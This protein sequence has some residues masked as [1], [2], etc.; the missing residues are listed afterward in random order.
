MASL[1][2]QTKPN[3]LT[4]QLV[5]HD[6]AVKLSEEPLDDGYRFWA[7][8]APKGSGK[9][10]VLYN[11]LENKASPWYKLFDRIYMFSPTAENT[12]Y[13]KPLLKELKDSGQFYHELNEKNL[14]ECLEHLEAFNHSFMNK[15]HPQTRDQKAQELVLLRH[16][17]KREDMPDS[18]LGEKVNKRKPHNLIIFDDCL[19]ELAKSTAKSIQSRLW[20]RNRHYFTNIALTSQRYLKLNPT[21]RNNLDSISFWKTANQKEYDTLE[22]DLNVDPKVLKR[23]YDFATKEPFSFLHITFNAGVPLFFRKF[24]RIVL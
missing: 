12:D 18:V 1:P 2:L 24:D 22:E 16:G 14:T 17:V 11:V 15:R 23:V 19:N 3:Q 13:M 8:I 20:T 4:K 10:C 6:N 9:T 5:P 21:I 7:L